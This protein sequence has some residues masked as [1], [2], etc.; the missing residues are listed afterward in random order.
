[1]TRCPK[2]TMII[3]SLMLASQ[4][5]A[6]P[7]GDES[8][9]QSMMADMRASAT[10]NDRA[11]FD[12]Q[13]RQQADA[14]RYSGGS[15]SSGSSAGNG[16]GSN[17]SGS[18]YAGGG[19]GPSR[20]TGPQS[21]VASYS[22]T[23]RRQESPSA[24]AT[25]LEQ[26]AGNGNALSAYNLGRVY[27][28]GFDGLARNDVKARQWFA[29]AAELGQ[30]GAQSQYGYMLHDAIGGGVD[31]A[32]ALQW[33]KKAADQ[34]DTYGEALFG[35]YTIAAKPIDTPAPE[36][37][38]M[39]R[40]AADKGDLLA[41]GTLGTIVYALGNGAPEDMTQSAHYSALAA[42]QGN[43]VAQ[44]QYGRL[45][46][47][48]GGIPKDEAAGLA[49]LR[50]AAAQNNTE[51]M[52]LLGT[53]AFTG[54]AMP[55]DNAAGASWFKRAADAGDAG[56]AGQYAQLLLGGNY[57]VTM[58]EAAGV[59]YARI[60]ADKGNINGQ[61]T[62]ARCYY[63]GNGVAVDMKPA[64]FWFRKAAAQGDVDAKKALA[65]PKMVEAA[66]G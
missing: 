13:Q 26:E 64:L 61:M 65:D 43:A 20:S 14:A 32:G 40:R 56:A 31:R 9:R 27:Y 52:I 33:T 42:A 17:S 15:G 21:I 24:V 53:L 12:S 4:A 22:F 6:D 10:A 34:G 59:R 50:K 63:N 3:C 30:P 62:L 55:Q 39:L 48:G 51:A 44:T 28:T 66:R 25:R 2:L 1:M 57:G 11:N 49:Q 23:I 16:S 5:H 29:K 54:Q 7:A 58:D 47:T 45:L 19:S 46:V 38:K 18:S 8:R 41:Q 36:A 60:S 37:V 35:F